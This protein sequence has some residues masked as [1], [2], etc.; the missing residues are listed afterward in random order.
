MDIDEVGTDPY[1]HTLLVT[2]STNRAFAI[3]ATSNVPASVTELTPISGNLVTHGEPMAFLEL[4]LVIIP[5]QNGDLLTMD[6]DHDTRLAKHN[7]RETTLGFQAF[8]S[9]DKLFVATM[10]R[11]R[12]MVQLRHWKTLNVLTQIEIEEGLSLMF[13]QIQDKTYLLTL[14][15][16]SRIEMFMLRDQQLEKKASF[17]TSDQLEDFVTTTTMTSKRAAAEHFLCKVKGNFLLFPAAFVSFSHSCVSSLSIEA[18]FSS[19]GIF[20]LCQAQNRRNAFGP[21]NKMQQKYI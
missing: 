6:L 18:Y 20:W 15:Q 17:V 11:L 5:C 21:L 12:P 7:E 2:T 13:S 14:S 19:R 16:Q 10:T 3:N 8:A 9:A 4:S 1:S